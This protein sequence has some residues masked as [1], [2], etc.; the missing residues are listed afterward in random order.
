LALIPP[1]SGYILPII[2]LSYIFDY[3]WYFL[4]LINLVFVWIAGPWI[5]RAYLVRLYTGI[6]GKDVLYSF[7][8]GIIALVI[9]IITYYI[10]TV[11]Q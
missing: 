7:I 1:I 4:F 3:H 2:P 5:T 8:L 9:G 11:N 6:L 10:F